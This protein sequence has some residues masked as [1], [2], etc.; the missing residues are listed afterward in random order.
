MLAGVSS[1]PIS[2]LV[3]Q[4]LQR[5]DNDLAEALIRQIAIAAHRP[6]SFAGG[7]AAVRTVLARRGLADGIRLVDGS[8]LSRLDRVTP[9][10]LTRLLVAAART[11]SLR[12]VVAGLAVGGFSGTLG[13][14]FRAAH[15]PFSPQPGAGVVRA[16]TGTLTGV[17]A[18][19]G[20]AVDAD[21]RLL[22]FAVIAPQVA[23]TGTVAADAA[24]DT[25]ADTLGRCGCS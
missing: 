19:A 18:L 15:P 6:A 2:A 10:A 9:L 14:R 24:L 13:S 25:V 12:P 4:M 16:K 17:S 20:L 3:A 11:P 8:G 22:A 21:G 1:A 7:S 23:P 5:S